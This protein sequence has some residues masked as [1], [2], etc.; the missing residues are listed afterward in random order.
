MQIKPRQ[1]LL[2]I[3]QAV[4]R[5]S[6]ES[7]EWDWGEEGGLSSVADAERLLCLMYPATEIP[8]FRLDDPDTLQH[9]VQTALKDVGGPTEIPVKLVRILAEFMD[10]Y[11][12]EDEGP[13][14]AGGHYF[15][16]CDP[17]EELTEEQRRLGVVDSFS[18]S[19]TLCLA[20]LGFL[21]VYRGR[22]RRAEV[23]AL[24][25][26]LRA[27][28][29]T[30]LTAAMVSLLRSFTVNVFDPDDPQGRTLCD[31]LGQGQISRRVVVERFQQRFK[32][33]RATVNER[34]VLG[35]DIAD[36]L[37]DQN[38]LFECGWAWTLVKDSPPVETREPIG[39]QPAGV[40][41]P[42]PYL[43]FTVVALDGIQDLS[44]ERTLTLGLL[45]PEQQR[46]AEAL[47]LRW[48]IT[49]QYWSGIARFGDV[50]PLEDIRWRTTGQ[51]M[52]SAYFSLSAASILV[53]DLVRRRATDED[54][55]RTVA[56]MERLAEHSRISSR[57]TEED[58]A[59]VLHAPGVRLAL[60]GSG[61]TGPPMQWTV[62]D[63]PAQLLK[64]SI[65]LCALSRN[66]S[67]HDRLL[68]LTERVFA[69]VWERRIRYGKGA[70]LW[71]DVQAVYPSAPAMERP[72]SWSFTERVVECMVAGH[73]LYN[74]A[75]LRSS[76]LVRSASSLLSE[77]THLF[78][79]EFLEPASAQDSSRSRA[80]K[81]VEAGLARA[82]EVLD[83]QPGTAMALV[84][85]ALAE[86][87]S[88]A[89]GRR[90]ASRG[91]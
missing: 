65:Q 8:A 72:P 68:R 90:A 2:D 57:M 64:R 15:D 85:G 88:L 29:E 43:Y 1:H 12:A 16:A 49:Q 19:I 76:E 78:G 75:P 39:R 81:S 51:S 66:V 54:L 41:W 33:L 14:F 46:L 28:T 73:W 87:D 47:R 82:R 38:Q 34:L 37:T 31:I 5:H 23:H 60:Q 74:Q 71:D 42:V 79:G 6:F 26:K 44:S 3:W 22:T 36:R 80:L 10:T 11:T 30:R 9:D 4:S 27:A 7:G 24:I 13:S 18:M 56:V 58:T 45:T 52:E 67:S 69:H 70:G 91:E 55:T 53:H 62:A 59:I 61:D 20:T 83:Q 84:L 77:A 32:A 48:E 25:E 63:F 21:K 89:R 17:G 50:W 40:A 35:V 86:L